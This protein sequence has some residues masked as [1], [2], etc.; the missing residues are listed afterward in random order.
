MTNGCNLQNKIK[1]YNVIT[2]RM[3]ETLIIKNDRPI[4][5]KNCINNVM[6]RT[7][8]NAIYEDDNGKIYT[9]FIHPDK[10]MKQF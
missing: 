10:P 4:L 3:K 1:N 7:E 9:D 6:D 8:D 5:Q 2:E